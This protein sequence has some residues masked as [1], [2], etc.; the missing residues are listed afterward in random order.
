MALVDLQHFSSR[1][2]GKFC[3]LFRCSSQTQSIIIRA[4]IVVADRDAK[5]AKEVV[6]E[7]KQL[8]RFEN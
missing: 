3:F 8:G 7:I 2:M 5:G 1:V 6:D 4:K